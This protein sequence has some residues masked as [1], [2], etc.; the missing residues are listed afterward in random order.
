MSTARVAA[1]R[2]G[3]LPQPYQIAE[4]TLFDGPTQIFVKID[5]PRHR[6][7]GHPV[8][9]RIGNGLR[10]RQRLACA[11]SGREHLTALGVAVLDRCR[12]VPIDDPLCGNPLV[13][14]PRMHGMSWVAAGDGV[15]VHGF[16]KIVGV[17][18][19]F[20][21]GERPSLDR[22]DVLEKPP[23]PDDVLCCG[24]IEKSTIEL[25]MAAVSER[26]L[27]QAAK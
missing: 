3:V 10:R 1:G 21:W 25:G 15:D 26:M 17:G 7:R 19:K 22:R 6:A 14:Q 24:S 13:A 2:S 16:G 4:L 9:A 8:E 5:R 12:L 27:K 23:Q 18:R 20:K 11:P